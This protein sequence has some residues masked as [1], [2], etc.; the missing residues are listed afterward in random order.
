[1][2]SCIIIVFCLFILTGASVYSQQQ[3]NDNS[4]QGSEKIEMYYFHT[5]YR[6]ATCLA[7]EE[8][9]KMAFEGL[10]PEKFKSGQASFQAVNIDEESSTD[11]VERYKVSGQLLLLVKG[12]KTVDLTS[13]GFLY[14]RTNPEKLREEIRKAVENL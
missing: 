5:S 6:C 8:Q 10:Y 9:S 1:M 11:L 4:A 14:A 12:D 3:T 7:V 13:Q 2:K